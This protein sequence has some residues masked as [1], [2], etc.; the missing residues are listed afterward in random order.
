MFR[1]E[2]ITLD[3]IASACG[4]CDLNVPGRIEKADDRNLARRYHQ[5]SIRYRR[6]ATKEVRRR[7][8]YLNSVGEK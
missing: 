6:I 4:P 2:T 5:Q 1:L 7:A 8:S 3:L